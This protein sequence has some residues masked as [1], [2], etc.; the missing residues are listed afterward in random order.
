[1]ARNSLEIA[2]S[3]GCA[4]HFESEFMYANHEFET[5]NYRHNVSIRKSPDEMKKSVLKKY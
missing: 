5:E 4:F 2:K 3:L 1:M